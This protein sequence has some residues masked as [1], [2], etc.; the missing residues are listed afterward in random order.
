[1]T[2]T[3]RNDIRN[4]IR[5]AVQLAMEYWPN[6]HLGTNTRREDMR[7]AFRMMRSWAEHES[8]QC[9]VGKVVSSAYSHAD[10]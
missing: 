8:I 2:S 4:D 1:M 7:S 9:A 6:S 3:I 10:M 5:N